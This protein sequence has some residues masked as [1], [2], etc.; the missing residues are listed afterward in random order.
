MLF[1]CWLRLEGIL[2]EQKNSRHGGNTIH[3]SLDLRN[4]YREKKPPNYEENGAIRRLKTF[5]LRETK[6]WKAEQRQ[7]LPG[8]KIGKK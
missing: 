4:I 2:T 6:A 1:M 5:E 8:G 3:V 7:R